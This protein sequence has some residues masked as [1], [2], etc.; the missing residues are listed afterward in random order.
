MDERERRVG[1]ARGGESRQALERR[2][3]R[4]ADHVLRE[5]PL[6]V[7]P[8]PERGAERIGR[9]VPCAPNSLAQ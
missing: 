5:P 1:A 4:E 7:V 9:E 8:L 6:H 2:G 3:M